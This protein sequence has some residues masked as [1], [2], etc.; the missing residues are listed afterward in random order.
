MLVCQRD[1]GV[2][3]DRCVFHR[4]DSGENRVAD[5]LGAVSVRRDLDS[6]RMRDL[7]D[8]CDLILGHLARPRC[9]AVGKHSTKGN[10]LE[11]IRLAVD[12]ELSVT[13]ELHRAA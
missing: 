4:I 7:Y 8:R 10:H 6:R 13:R 1:A 5:R 11:K 2:V 12:G 3:D 9:V